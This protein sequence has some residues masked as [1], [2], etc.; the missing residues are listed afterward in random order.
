M[1][2]RRKQDCG[3]RF[4]PDGNIFVTSPNINS[5]ESGELTVRQLL[6]MIGLKSKAGDH[7]FI[8]FERTLEK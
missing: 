6:Q 8:S 5:V 4:K 7:Y 2:R 1:G 3:L